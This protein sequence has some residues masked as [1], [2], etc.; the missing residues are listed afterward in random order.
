MRAVVLARSLGNQ[1]LWILS[2]FFKMNG[3][4]KLK[5]KRTF[6]L[7]KLSFSQSLH[8]WIYC[9]IY[10]E[11]WRKSTLKRSIFSFSFYMVF[12]V[13]WDINVYVRWMYAWK[14][15]LNCCERI[16]PCQDKNHRCFQNKNNQADDSLYLCDAHLKPSGFPWITAL[17]FALL[18]CDGRSVSTLVACPT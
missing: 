14:C 2:H 7:L 8:K 11:Y 4:V 1:G 10:T 13:S 16:L 6:I 5:F 18:G 12:T 9:F 3:L 17:Q 15:S